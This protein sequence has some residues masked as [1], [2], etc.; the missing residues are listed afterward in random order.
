MRAWP[1]PISRTMLGYLKDGRLRAVIPAKDSVK[2]KGE[3]VYYYNWE[4][5]IRR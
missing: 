5:E 1:G 4:N 3:G 2:V